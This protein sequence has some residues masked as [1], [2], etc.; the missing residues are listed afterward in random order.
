MEQQQQQAYARWGNGFVFPPMNAH[1][2]LPV[3]V[4]PPCQNVGQNVGQPFIPFWNGP[5]IPPQFTH[6]VQSGHVSMGPTGSFSTLP[7][8]RAPVPQVP[9]LPQLQAML[10]SAET[11]AA[12]RAVS[13]A[14]PP[15]DRSHL[16]LMTTPPPAVPVL[17]RSSSLLKRRDSFEPEKGSTQVRFPCLLIYSFQG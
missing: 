2:S 14:S 4:V 12:R 6:S 16:D 15:L 10:T 3:P 1:H 7:L 5:Y 17:R 11:P 9:Q 8:S 13:N